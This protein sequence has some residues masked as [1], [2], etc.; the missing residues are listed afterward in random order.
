[1]IYCKKTIIA[2][3]FTLM[4]PLAVWSEAPV[5]DD[6]DNF[7]II[8]GQ[9][10]ETS[11]VHPKYDDPQIESAQVDG[12]QNENYQNDQG[13]DGPALVKEEQGNDSHNTVND[14]AKLID[15]L[16]ALQH[17]IQELRGQLEVQAHELKILKDQQLTFYKDL[18][19][20]LA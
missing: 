12:P 2:A 17:D 6:S 13:D 8:D 14:S 10:M 20:R 11:G 18:D 3:C 7:A 16:Q 1:M 9:Q 4:L 15:K 19:S 5:V